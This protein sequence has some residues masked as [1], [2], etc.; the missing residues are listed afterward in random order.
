MINLI[1]AEE[2]NKQV[3]V[4]SALVSEFHQLHLLKSKAST[5]TSTL[6]APLNWMIAIGFL[7]HSVS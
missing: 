5:Y 7:K 4:F 1:S 6:R 2:Q 3:I